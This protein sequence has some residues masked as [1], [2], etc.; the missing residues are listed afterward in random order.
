M[1]R[2]RVTCIV[3]ITL[4]QLRFRALTDREP[5]LVARYFSM[6]VLE[7]HLQRVGS[8]PRTRY[9]RLPNMAVADALHCV[10]LADQIGTCL[11]GFHLAQNFARTFT[12]S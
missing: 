7:G 12:I 5:N 8:F 3:L 1:F 10:C 2:P 11:Q 4:V 9:V 6:C